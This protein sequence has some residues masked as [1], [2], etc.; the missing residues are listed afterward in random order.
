MKIPGTL[1][2]LLPE[3]AIGKRLL[4]KMPEQLLKENY[5]DAGELFGSDVS[6]LYMGECVGFEDHLDRWAKYESEYANR[7]Y[8]TI[9]V[10]KFIDAGGYGKD[11]SN[12]LGQ[13]RK[14]GEKPILHAKIYRDHFL[15]KMRSA[16]DH[17]ELMEAREGDIQVIDPQVGDITTIGEP[18]FGTYI[19]PST[20][21]LTE[22]D[23]EDLEDKSKEV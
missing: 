19:L 11:I 9:S 20:E 8:K 12:L 5:L 13:K 17:N 7:G 4:A 10:D 14:E 15:G 1:F 18:R 3:A 21:I 22:R 2:R 16:I 6:Y 23:N